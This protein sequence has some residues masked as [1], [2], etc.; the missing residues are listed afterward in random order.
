M[1]AISS[2]N[3]IKYGLF[4]KRA[5][6]S[7]PAK[8]LMVVAMAGLTG[9]LAQVRIP[10]PF[11]PVPVTGQ[12]L[13]MLMAGVLLGKWWGGA[14]MAVYAAAGI[15]GVPWFAGLA[16]GLGATGGYILGFIPAALFLGHFVDKY[17]ESRRLIPLMGLML[18]AT[19][20]Y[21]IPG[22]AWLALWMKSAGIAVSFTGVIMAGVAPFIL[23]DIFKAVIAG[24][25]SF[26]V[27]PK[28]DYSA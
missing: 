26:A 27:V 11:T 21:Y 2:I 18:A 10:L 9:L 6:M 22:A 5:S 28:Q 13:A 23:I 20:I 19:L 7:I 16:S 3:R 24:L 12:V 14:S 8:L 17:V 4:Q 15:A 1:Q 25:I